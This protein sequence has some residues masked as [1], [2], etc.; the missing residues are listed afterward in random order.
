MSLLFLST[1]KVAASLW[2]EVCSVRSEVLVGALILSLKFLD[3][4]D[5]T[6]VVREKNYLTVYF[7]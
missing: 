5:V 2:L 6:S 4:L 7:H 1:K 3:H